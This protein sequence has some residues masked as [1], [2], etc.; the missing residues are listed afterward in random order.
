MTTASRGTSIIGNSVLD[1]G[2]KIKADLETHSLAELVGREYEGEWICDWTSSIESEMEN[3]Q[4]HYSYSYATQVV[5]LDDSGQIETV[6]AAHDAGRII[7]PVLFEGQ[8]E[9]SVHMG[10]GYALSENFEMQ[11]GRPRH[12]KLG[13]LGMIRAGSTPKIVVI[14][15]EEPDEFGPCGAK[16][17][18]EIGLVPTASAV[19]NAFFQY[20]GERQ[21]E[22]PLK[23]M[24]IKSDAS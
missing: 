12:T 11:E 21:Y 8:L 6:Y 7:N 18:G 2:S 3:P 19:S 4:T 1:A 24:N 17:V 14:G 10:L 23:K 5:T 20:N 15:V 22:L 16:G 13:K 9:G